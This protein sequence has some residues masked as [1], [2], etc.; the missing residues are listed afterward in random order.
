MSLILI[1]DTC[2]DN[3]F[4]CLSS[5]GSIIAKQDNSIQNQHASFIHPA[6]ELLFK[7]AAVSLQDID[8]VAVVNGPGSYT[9]LRVGLSSAKGICYSI[10]K[11]LIL[12]NT[13]YVMAMALRNNFV[14]NNAS[15]GNELFCPL[16]D[17]RRMEV[18][19]GIYDINLKEILQQTNLIIDKDSFSNYTT[20]HLIV[21]GGSGSLKVMN[22]VDNKNCLFPNPAD[23][24]Q[25][26]CLIASERYKNNEFDSLIYSEPFYLK[27]FYSK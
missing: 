6:I 17:A 10:N 9:G 18:Y 27:E 25:E 13:L 22:C 2:G 23:Y 16:I 7:N 26:A 4:V 14:N 5:K 1:I 3:A 20:D 12:I 8:A 21:F 11:P 15:K 24:S 19:T